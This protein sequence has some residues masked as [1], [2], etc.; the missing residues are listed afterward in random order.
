[1]QGTDEVLKIERDVDAHIGCCESFGISKN[2]IEATEQ[3]QGEKRISSSNL[4]RE[5]S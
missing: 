3:C 1:M 2:Q 4:L 5:L